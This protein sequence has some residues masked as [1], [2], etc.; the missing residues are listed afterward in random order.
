THA[1]DVY[2]FVYL[3]PDQRALKFMA[4][5]YQNVSQN[6]F[7]KAQQ[8]DYGLVQKAAYEKW[9]GASNYITLMLLEE[10]FKEKRNT[11]VHGTTSTGP[12]AQPLV[13]GAKKA[14]YEII[15]LLCSAPD[16][17]RKKVIHY[18]NTEQRFYQSTPEDAVSKGIMFPQRMQFFFEQ[19]DTLYL[20]WS[21][22]LSNAERLAAI[23]KAG[24]EIVVD[25]DAYAAFKEKYDSD[26][27]HLD[28]EDIA[29][30][31]WDALVDVYKKRFIA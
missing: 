30:S 1:T 19:G 15:F 28:K 10:A 4:N 29:L 5:T 23:F 16:E 24:K 13:Q 27:Q 26:A 17:F 20:Y 7:T 8:D 6:A 18:R 25:V 9:R 22:S 2:P 31:A 12:L 11:I 14:G 21:D 3:D